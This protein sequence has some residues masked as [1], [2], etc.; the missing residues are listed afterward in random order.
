M[1]MM[2][3]NAGDGRDAG[4]SGDANWNYDDDDGHDSD[5]VVDSSYVG[6]GD[7]DRGKMLDDSGGDALCPPRRNVGR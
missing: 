7:D 3:D 1:V 2:G 5:D 4:D 6:D